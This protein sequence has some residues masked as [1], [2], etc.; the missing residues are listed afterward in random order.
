MYR[1][2]FL[3]AT[4]GLTAAIRAELPAEVDRA[5]DAYRTEG[6]PGWAYTQTTTGEGHQ[7]IERFDPG[8]PELLRWTLMEKDGKA[9]ATDELEQYRGRKARRVTATGPPPLRDQI[10][11]KSAQLVTDNP[12]GWV[13]RF[14]LRPGGDDDSAA[15]FMRVTAFIGRASGQIERLSLGNV[16]PFSPSFLVR[17]EEMRTEMTYSPSNGSEP[18]HLLRVETRIRGRAFFRS[19]DQELT[20]RYSDFEKAKARMD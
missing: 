12:A 13:Y 5:L 19:L 2:F 8:R 6:A 16:V 7:T 3:L 9:P 10:D 17:V 1:T 11:R 18:S 20:V 14:R 4:A 15:A